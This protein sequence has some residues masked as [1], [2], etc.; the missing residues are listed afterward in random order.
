MI[1]EVKSLWEIEE[2]EVNELVEL[3]NISHIPLN[4]Q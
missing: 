3:S 2:L 4:T 1:E